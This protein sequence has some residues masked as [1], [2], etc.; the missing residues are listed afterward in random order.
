MST[1][2]K[3]P[4]ELFYEHL[5]I[6][7]IITA[8]AIIGAYFVTESITPSYRSQARCYLPTITETI[9]LNSE[10]G[11]IPSSPLLPTANTDFQDSL[12]GILKGADTRGAVA[13]KIEGRDSEWIEENVEFEIDRYNLVTI[14]AYD[15][16]SAIAKEVAEEY[17][18]TFQ[19]KLDSATKERAMKLLETFDSGIKVTLVELTTMEEERLNFMREHGAI[20]FNSELGQLT[21]RQVELENLL[22]GAQ[23][24]LASLLEQRTAMAQHL[25][26]RPETS[27]SVSTLINN[28]LL[29]G[30]RRE[31]SE[32]NR[33]LVGLELEFKGNHPDLVAKR[34]EI[35]ALESQIAS[36][37][38]VIRGTS[39]VTPDTLRTEL[40]SR[41]VDL[42]LEEADLRTKIA[43]Y[44]DALAATKERRLE[45]SVLQADL[46][47]IEARISAS[48]STVGN[49]RDR[50]AELELYEARNP[51]FLVV[52]EYPI[53][54]SKPYLPIM[55]VNL[56]VAGILGFT[57]AI[58]MVLV[59]DQVRQTREAALW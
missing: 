56:L 11:N 59:L 30:L 7:V 19:G 43:S 46:E 27:E 6:L 35:A 25:E 58:C 9:S 38:E 37:E 5:Y 26:S 2:T 48:R 42:D 57:T 15:P 39:T 12:L 54:A 18:R 3:G 13:A 8:V 21:N 28:P 51:T 17:L 31:L 14:T 49:Y 44:T 47:S 1:K 36:E 33:D 53:E 23:T 24:Q 50:K 10:A 40:N 29:E 20:D 22:S 34:E 45:L 32:A 55:W 41:L 4:F 52:P 16:D